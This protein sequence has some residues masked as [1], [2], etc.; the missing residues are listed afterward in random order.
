M[1]SGGVLLARV[2]GMSMPPVPPQ[3]PPTTGRDVGRAV[4][5]GLLFAL[6]TLA[7]PGLVGAALLT[8]LLWTKGSTNAASMSTLVTV[9]MAVALVGGLGGGV[10][11]SWG[12]RPVPEPA[13]GEEPTGEPLT[14]RQQSRAARRPRR[15]V[16]LPAFLFGV[17][18]VLVSIGARA[19]TVVQD[20]LP[21]G[22]GLAPGDGALLGGSLLALAGAAALAGVASWLVLRR[23][24]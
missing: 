2:L 12:R 18:W 20:L 24:A 1:V 4:G 16:L 15:S 10:L 17:S 11:A 6:G 22:A 8:L 14:R 23:R 21:G 7:V 13:P 19:V 9:G 5:A 3:D